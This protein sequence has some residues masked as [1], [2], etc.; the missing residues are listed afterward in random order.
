MKSPFK[1]LDAYTLADKDAYFGRE[2]ETDELYRMVFKTP[3]LLIYGVSGT[4]KTSLIQCGL[5]S[6]F[7]GPDWFPLFIRRQNNVNESLQNALQTAL[8]GENL[9]STLVEHVSYLYR[10]Y[11]RPIYLIFDQFE[12][13]FILGKPEEKAQLIQDLKALLDAKLPCKILLTMR[14]EYI[15][16]LYDFEKE[17]P[18]LFDFKLRLEP[19]NSKKVKGVLAQ[20]FQR[21]HIFTEAPEE[22]RL[23][24]IV[25]NLSA[26]KSGIQLPYLQVYLDMLYREDFARTYARE[27]EGDELPPLTFTKEEIDRFGRIENVLEKFLREQ[28]LHLQNQLLQSYPTLPS[29]TV[30]QVLDAFVTEEG[31]KCPV[32]FWRAEGNLVLDEKVME[33]L[34]EISPAALTECLESLERSRIVRFTGEN[35]E[36]AHDTLAALIDRQRSDQQRQLNDIKRR[37]Q[38]GYEEF[39]QSGDYLSRRQLA[40]FE[41][42]LPQLRLEPEVKNYIEA[43]R[44]YVETQE[45][46]ERERQQRE[47]TLAQEKLAAE[48]RATRRQRIYLLVVGIIAVIAFGLGF[49]AYEQNGRFKQQVLQTVRADI[50]TLRNQGQYVEAIARIQ[51]AR[52]LFTANNRRNLPQLDSQLIDLQKIVSLNTL[53]DSIFNI[54]DSVAIGAP[55]RIERLVE[56]RRRYTE[57]D[58]LYTDF[59]TNNKVLQVNQAIDNLFEFYLERAEE[60]LKYGNCAYAVPILC[61]AQTLKPD[62]PVILN[63]FQQCGAK[64]AACAQPS[65]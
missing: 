6:R 26:G 29:H 44:A 28:E 33:L 40:A 52:N 65:R 35:I 36:L 14:E 57:M 7:D 45:R 64:P 24:Q 51:N 21:F 58:S 38:A 61:S 8:N 17:I 39:L 30:R 25:E 62:Q 9:R 42:F 20:S 37:I 50:N 47:L 48:Q 32:R 2:Q 15:G 54:P 5:A 23:E 12:E 34:P 59:N 18:T 41:E 55:A 49:W 13:L 31:T 53:A 43:S 19:M 60:M 46:T 10:F 22:E 11:L 27:R 16:Q 56:A 4:G 1:F 63:G 3:L